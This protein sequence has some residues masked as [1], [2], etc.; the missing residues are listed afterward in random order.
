MRTRV[1]A[2][3]VA[4]AAAISLTAC[5][6]SPDEQKENVPT[7]PPA[8][9]AESPRG[10]AAPVG[11][12]LAHGPAAGVVTSGT[13]TAVRSADGRTLTLMTGPGAPGSPAPRTVTI[14]GAGLVDLIAAGDGFLGVGPD[15][16]Y[17][18]GPDGAVRQA[19]HTIDEPLSVALRDGR[20]LVGTARGQL[21]VFESDDEISDRIGGFVRVDQI[22]VAPDTAD[23]VKGKVSV[24]DRAQ[25]AVLPVDVESGEHKAALRAGNGAANAVIDRYGRISVTGPRDNEFY[26]F[27]GAPIVMRL[28]HP[29]P[30][31][32][33]AIAYDHER[34]LLW[35]SSTGTNEA[36]AY[37]LSTGDARERGRI[38]T[39][40]Q[41]SSM[42]VDPA[43]GSL[44]LVS[45][46]GDGVQVVPADAVHA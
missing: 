28:R 14:P 2:G 41:V 11:V 5:G 35:V 40:G 27:F 19:R 43:T 31:G 6:G 3:L 20:P 22:L 26:G 4:A 15:G 13:T 32:P 25:S 37:D 39:I 17:R 8:T 29:A 18:I 36:I 23:Q 44:I 16:L 33:Y 1:T 21:L 30:A 7:V 24:L 46:R 42:T 38:A 45:A 9:A 12:V 34:N 10:T